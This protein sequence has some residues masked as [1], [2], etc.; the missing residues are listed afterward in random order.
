M[1][2]SPQIHRVKSVIKESYRRFLNLRFPLSLKSSSESKVNPPL[3]K[4]SCK[5]KIVKSSTFKSSKDKFSGNKC[6]FVS[7]IGWLLNVDLIILVIA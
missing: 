3:V 7:E 2:N 4:S 5:A 6:S 1:G